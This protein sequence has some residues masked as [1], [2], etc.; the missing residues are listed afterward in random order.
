MP[1]TARA[2]PGAMSGASAVTT[3]YGGYGRPYGSL[4]GR[5]SMAMMSG[6][7]SGPGSGVGASPSLSVQ[8]GATGP[9]FRTD[10]S[11]P[12]S[13][14]GRTPSPLGMGGVGIVPA[15]GG[16][17]AG[18]APPPAG[19]S[20]SGPSGPPSGQS[21]VAP[22]ATSAGLDAGAAGPSR[23][24]PYQRTPSPNEPLAEADESSF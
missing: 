6:G 3:G 7:L 4:G 13:S 2:A 9:G 1:S 23:R 10:G 19:G 17:I 24:T 16:G 21:G 20:V 8:G 15:D 5:N 22:V 18:F 14:R 11:G 12:G